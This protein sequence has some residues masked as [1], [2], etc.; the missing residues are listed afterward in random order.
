M[1]LQM[2]MK[3]LASQESG[4]FVQRRC[5]LV[6]NYGLYS[7][8]HGNCSNFVMAIGE[9][10]GVRG[11]SDFCSYRHLKCKSGPVHHLCQSLVMIVELCTRTLF[12]HLMF[13]LILLALNKSR[14]KLSWN[15]FPQFTLENSDFTA[16]VGQSKRF[17]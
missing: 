8:I 11:N 13:Y 5:P 7:S 15:S 6:P 2:E 16:F 3:T 9:E 10:E 14:D 12:K 1:P 4:S 17:T